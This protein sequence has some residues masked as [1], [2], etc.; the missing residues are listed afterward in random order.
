MDSLLLN[1]PLFLSFLTIFASWQRFIARPYE[2]DV[3]LMTELATQKWLPDSCSNLLPSQRQ[4]SFCFKASS[5]LIF[6]DLLFLDLSAF[7]GGYSFPS[8]FR[9]TFFFLIYSRFESG[10]LFLLVLLWSLN[11]FW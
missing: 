11:A 4:V 1:S 3:R 7:C 10:F 8:L 6:Y 2:I 5:M 9:S